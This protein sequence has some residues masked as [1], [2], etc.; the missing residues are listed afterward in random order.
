MKYYRY[1][2]DKK[3][4]FD[5]IVYTFLF[6]FIFISGALFYRS[7]TIPII[8]DFT[9]SLLLKI[10]RP[11]SLILKPKVLLSIDISLDDYNAL[12]SQRKEAFAIGQLIKTQDSYVPAKINYKK[13]SLKCKIRLKGD[14][15]DHMFGEKWSFR[16]KI[17]DNKTLLGMNTF[18]LQHPKTRNYLKEKI[19]YS[20]AQ[21]LNL[22]SLRY[23][24]VNL[25]INGQNKGI[26]ALEEHFSKNLIE[27]NK[28]REGP[29]LKFDESTTWNNEL[30]FRNLKMEKWNSDGSFNSS[31]VTSFEN[32]NSLAAK[33]PHQ[34]ELYLTGISLLND[35]QSG[36][37]NVVDVFNIDQWAKLFA[38]CDITGSQHGVR[39]H[40][41]RFY[42][43]PINR[44]IEPIPYDA[45]GG[46]NPHNIIPIIIGTENS[47]RDIYNSNFIKQIFSDKVIYEKYLYYI[48]KFLEEDL[49]GNFFKQNEKDIYFQKTLLHGEFPKSTINYKEFYEKQSEYIANFLNPQMSIAGY[50]YGNNHNQFS[51]GNLQVLPVE[52][53]DII[54]DRGISYFNFDNI[55]LPGKS[56][57]KP[58][59]LSFF[60]INGSMKEHWVSNHGYSELKIRHK[61]LG[62][63]R[64]LHSNFFIRKHLKDFSLDNNYSR[65]ILKLKDQK[66][67]EINLD[68]KVILVKKGK[69]IIRD[70][71]VVPPN[72]KI[73][74][75]TNTHLDF[76]NS[77]KLISYSPI[78]F[79]G[80]LSQHSSV[81]SSD[82]SSGGITVMNSNEKTIFE[83]VDFSNLS[84]L[85]ENSWFLSGSINIYNSKVCFRHCSFI[86]LSGG[87]DSL[88]VINS[89]FDIEGCYFENSSSD[90]IDVDYGSGKID[91]T[92]FINS[93]NDAIDIS[94]ANVSIEN[95][96][97]DGAQDKA[98]SVGERS[99][100][101]MTNISINRAEI[102]I[103]SKDGSTVNAEA[104]DFNNTRVGLCAFRKK[105]EFGPAKIISKSISGLV[106][107]EAPFLLEKESIIT[108]DS[109]SISPS[110][111]AVR[112]LLYGIKYGK[113][114]Q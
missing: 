49:I 18:S 82:N 97:I 39:W 88:N 32:L 13:N 73:I 42:Y 3:N 30:K 40:N 90:A 26:Y 36:R 99:N 46:N 98:I 61:I 84:N 29:I 41:V 77:A 70:R 19:F 75:G 15:L 21:K 67:T 104:I 85:R 74:I 6:L 65:M 48:H 2:K 111:N 34:Y 103:T 113:S 93:G 27:N 78:I 87:D 25:T 69:W 24:F 37:K 45:N 14:N 58:V 53:I 35:F 4:F 12:K 68:K 60:S 79:K 91:D 9:H 72:Y 63:S 109:T 51:I 54:D 100:V 64:I 105:S 56:S 81:T 66:F 101:V 52:L 10:D 16:V 47:T 23:H 62:S 95:V 102:G 33:N 106:R 8:K 107:T 5:I 20:L 76:I 86:N 50:Y 17:K 31:N 71:L 1:K 89:E 108:H 7:G 57:S 22:I 44:K 94:G 11:E 80:S 92:T 59:K 55:Q 110:S 96:H 83:R 43:N 114:S 38:L 28:R 112:S